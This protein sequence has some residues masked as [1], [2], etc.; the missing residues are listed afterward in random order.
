M[1]KL[2]K[3]MKKLYKGT[4]GISIDNNVY[5]GV[6]TGYVTKI[7]KKTTK[8]INKDSFFRV[9]LGIPLIS[10]LFVDLFTEQGNE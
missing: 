5:N 9:F 7:Y 1:E 6:N 10:T 8:N 3:D 4:E 2:Y